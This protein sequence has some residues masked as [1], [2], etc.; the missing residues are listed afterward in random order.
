MGSILDVTAFLKTNTSQFTSGMKNAGRTTRGFSK[1]MSMLKS[2]LLT[3]FSVGAVVAFGKASL[4]AYDEQIKGET[5]LLTAMKGRGEAT[6]EMVGLSS[7]LQGKTLFADEQSIDAMA[8]MAAIM[9]DNKEAIKAL[10]PLVQDFATV[11]GM[12]LASAAELVGKAFA[13]TTNPLKRYGIELKGTAGSAERL[14]SVTQQLTKHFGGQAEAA[15]LVGLGPLEQLKNQF[16][17]IQEEIGKGLLPMVNA[18]ATALKNLFSQ[19][20]W[21]S[22]EEWTRL[23]A[24]IAR[25]S[26]IYKKMQDLN[27]KKA[28]PEELANFQKHFLGGGS[29]SSTP[30]FTPQEK[31]AELIAGWYTEINEDQKKY[32]LGLKEEL[33]WLK[34]KEEYYDNM[35]QQLDDIENFNDKPIV[36]LG[37]TKG[38][39][40]TL[41]GGIGP[42]N[43]LWDDQPIKDMGKSVEELTNGLLTQNQAVGILSDSFMGFFTDAQTGWKNMIDTFSQAINRFLADMAAKAALWLILDLVTGGTAGTLKSFVLPQLSKVATGGTSSQALDL[44]GQNV[45]VGGDFK[46]SGKD[47]ALSL[48]RN[49]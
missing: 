42:K 8:R 39:K 26:G 1:E 35:I 41:L 38:K 49:A 22:E 5:K 32:L 37:Q 19:G 16:N 30:N 36:G 17:D 28:T 34:A 46:I 47:L 11:K 44:T 15:A 48:R 25:G 12:D 4:K 18:L 23:D 7:K 9:G 2:Q 33:K 31:M 29:G 14:D 45:N 3:V 10:L 13:S 43:P 20:F 27:F 24:M 6:K 21:K 40:D